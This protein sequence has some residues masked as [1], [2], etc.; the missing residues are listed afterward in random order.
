MA[1]TD[2]RARLSRIT[3]RFPSRGHAEKYDAIVWGDSAAGA[4]DAGTDAGSD[5][6]EGTMFVEETTAR[7][8]ADGGAS[9]LLMM[10]K[11]AG[12]WRFAAVSPEG[13]IVSDSR[14]APC[15]ECHR[16]AP[17]DYVFRTPARAAGPLLAPP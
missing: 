14:V 2:F 6:A 7:G 12:A 8:V 9:G 17:H 4:A 3:G 5:F 15:G 16:E 1:P 13:E 11:R 10:E